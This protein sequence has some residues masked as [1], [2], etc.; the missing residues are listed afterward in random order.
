LSHRQLV[1]AVECKIPDPLKLRR[2]TRKDQIAAP[3]EAA[4]GNR[5]QTPSPQIRGDQFQVILKNS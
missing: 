2:K 3:H 4:M 1:A 5:L